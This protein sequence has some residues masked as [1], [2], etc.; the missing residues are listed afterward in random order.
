MAVIREPFGR[1]KD[2][3]EVEKL[4]LRRGTL[5]AE[6]LTYGGVVAALRTADRTG[7]MVDVVLGYRT[8]A[9]Y[10]E[11][12]GYLG[13]L[14]GRYANRIGGAR[15]TI[16][17]QTYPLTANEGAKQLHGGPEGF[18]FQAVSYTHLDVYKRQPLLNHPA[19][20]AGHPR[21]GGHQHDGRGHQER[22]QDQHR[23]AGQGAG[24]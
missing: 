4:T 22:R 17:G 15:I 12:G 14:V 11:N 18:S 5:E 23:A 7:T 9:G 16:D 19:H 2:G 24:L 1:T 10:E 20:R 6:V 21:G 13:A 3:R 8:L